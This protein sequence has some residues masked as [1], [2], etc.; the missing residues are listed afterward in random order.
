MVTKKN[1]SKKEISNQVLR[2][3]LFNKYYVTNVIGGLTNQDFRFDLLNEKIAKEDGSWT[4]ISDA[5]I[6]LTP[7]GAKRLLNLLS[8]TITI[9]EKENG[10]IKESDSKEKVIKA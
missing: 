8:E 10:E 6:I 1:I 9:Y 3:P 2:A 4:Y 5:L 7:L